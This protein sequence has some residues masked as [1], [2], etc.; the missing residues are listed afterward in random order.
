MNIPSELWV[1]KHTQIATCGDQLVATEGYKKINKLSI[2]S[3]QTTCVQRE[4][5]WRRLTCKGHLAANETMKESKTV[6]IL[7]ASLSYQYS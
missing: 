7:L 5:F 4:L 2:D 6:I 1:K 3:C